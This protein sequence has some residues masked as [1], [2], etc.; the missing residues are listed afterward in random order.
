MRRSLVLVA[1]SCLAITSCSAPGP[2]RTLQID[3][4]QLTLS[5]ASGHMIDGTNVVLV[6]ITAPS[7][8]PGT[9][10][11]PTIRFFMPAMGGMPVMDERAKLAPTGIAGQYRARLN[12]P[13]TGTWQTTIAFRTPR[14]VER[15]MFDVQAQ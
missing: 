4:Y 13:S 7:G 15:T 5:T 14:G 2:L 10:Q 12:T 3:G 11:Q 9:V 6:R 1:A 8:H